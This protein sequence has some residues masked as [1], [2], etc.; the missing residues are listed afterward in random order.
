MKFKS[1]YLTVALFVVAVALLAFSA[2][3]SSQAA[4]TYFSDVYGAEVSMHDI[5]VTLTENGEDVSNRD[6]TGADDLWHENTGVLVAHIPDD[7]S[8][9][10][11]HAYEEALGVTN[12]GNIDE[13]VRVTIYRYWAEVDEKGNEVRKFR[14]LDP[15]LIDLNILTGSNGWI[16]DEAA[17]TDERTV[18]YYQHVLPIGAASPAFSDT[19]TIWEGD[20]TDGMRAT[21][22]KTVEETAE[23]T[24]ITTTYT[25]DGIK[26]ILRVD[27]D[28]V[29][30]HNAD[31]AIRSAWGIDMGEFGIQ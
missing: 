12:S 2:V 14:D 10:L 19:L 17:R 27:V 5:G 26:F 25:Y 18:L 28:A 30:T 23:G 15:A 13:Y 16:E 1:K 20:G 31:D 3:G 29:Q 4:L 9:L 7:G 8:M 24:K 6:Y 21:V 22:T 11:N